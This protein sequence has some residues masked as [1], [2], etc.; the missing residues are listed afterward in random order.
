M[1]KINYEKKNEDA[2]SSQ[3]G[4]TTMVNVFQNESTLPDLSKRQNVNGHG[5][6]NVLIKSTTRYIEIVEQKF[7]K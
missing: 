4:D 2:A 7:L 1:C 3:D 6:N 5:N